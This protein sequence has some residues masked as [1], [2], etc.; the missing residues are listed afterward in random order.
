ML[1]LSLL[2][3]SPLF[4]YLL[5]HHRNIAVPFLK[6]QTIHIY[7][8]TLNTRYVS[9]PL[10]CPTN[11]FAISSAFVPSRLPSKL[12]VA[13]SPDRG[14]GSGPCFEVGKSSRDFEKLRILGARMAAPGWTCERLIRDARAMLHTGIL[15]YCSAAFGSA[16]LTN[17]R[18]F[19]NFLHPI[20]CRH[21]FEAR[22]TVRTPRNM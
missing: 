21:S 6:A 9:L 22:T 13:I 11:S 20:T 15:L 19:V 17:W 1:I 2:H 14:R 5:E 4:H 8:F 12:R 16:L 18:A 10:Q 7:I 3:L